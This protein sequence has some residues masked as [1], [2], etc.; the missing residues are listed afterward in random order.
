MSGPTSAQPSLLPWLALM[1]AHAAVAAA[2]LAVLGAHLSGALREAGAAAL[3]AAVAAALA[4][5]GG[6][7]LNDVHDATIDRINRPGRP[8]PSGAVSPA[9]ARRLAAAAFAAAVATAALASPWCL[10]V[11]LVNCALLALY[12]VRSKR[13]GFGKGLVVAYLVASTVLFGA[14]DPARVEVGTACLA[15]CAGL[16]TLA[17]ELV[18]DIEDMA[19]DRAAGAATLPLRIGPRNARRIADLAL[20]AAVAVSFVPWLVRPAPPPSLVVLVLGGAV[21]GLSTLVGD[22]ARAQRLIMAGSLVAGTA[23]LLA[24]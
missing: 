6:N 4:T 9:A 20:L 18:K 5:I 17:R 10:A 22:A 15:L 23:Y 19:G 3:L 12:A 14:L 21:L 13:L 16:A 8:I 24:A 11:A 2:L 1:R 7:A